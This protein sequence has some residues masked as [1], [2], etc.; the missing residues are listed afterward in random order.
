MNPT[1]KHTIQWQASVVNGCEII[2]K[3][4]EGIET[5]LASRRKLFT[6][7]FTPTHI[8]FPL[9]Q[10]HNFFDYVTKVAL[11]YRSNHILITMGEDFNYQ[12]AT[13]WFKNIDKLIK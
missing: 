11:G 8:Y 13:M 9:L 10:L 4:I 5:F 2:F 12:D 3:R 1:I 6:P 7:F